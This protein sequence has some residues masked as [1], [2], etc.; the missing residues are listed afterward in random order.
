MWKWLKW[1][2]KIEVKNWFFQSL[3]FVFFFNGKCCSATRNQ[4]F[5]TKSS[6]ILLF[7]LNHQFIQF[8]F[9]SNSVCCVYYKLFIFI[10]W[11][12]MM[13]HNTYL[14]N[15]TWFKSRLLVIYLKSSWRILTKNEFG[16]K[17]FD[18]NLMQ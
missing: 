14:L 15:Q 16:Y 7:S 11:Y 18:Q 12:I 4:M 6:L 9:T 8:F 1:L 17:K 13:E 10:P 5:V 2:Y 3:S